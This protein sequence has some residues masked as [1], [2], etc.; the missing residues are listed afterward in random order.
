MLEP[1]DLDAI[2]A[3]HLSQCGPCD[4]ALPY[5]CQCSKADP[6][7][8]IARLVDELKRLRAELASAQKVLRAAEAYDERH[9]DFLRAI[10]PEDALIGEGNAPRMA[11]L[12][13][14]EE[15]RQTRGESQ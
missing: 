7:P 6:R 2:A 5:P 1:L 3:E 4:Y 11:L 9:G 13:A 14:L 12:D 15:Y 10:R 8:V